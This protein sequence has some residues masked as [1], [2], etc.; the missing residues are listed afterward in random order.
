MLTTKARTE[1][2]DA[3]RVLLGALNGIAALLAADSK[4]SEAV[5]AY[6]QVRHPGRVIVDLGSQQACSHEQEAA[7]SA[8]RSGYSTKPCAP[9]RKA[10]PQDQPA[11]LHS[12]HRLPGPL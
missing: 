9:G 11:V 7:L 1:A 5:A 3:Q 6:R 4:T 2:E 8:S 10:P 12:L